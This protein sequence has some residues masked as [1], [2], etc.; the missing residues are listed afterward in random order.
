HVFESFDEVWLDIG[1]TNIRSQKATAKL[2]AKKM[3]EGRLDLGTGRE[4]D[5]L[6][7]VVS[8]AE[9]DKVKAE[10]VVT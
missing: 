4:D 8:R 5:Y 2:G 10:R 1:P 6:S 7:F 3:F 9:W